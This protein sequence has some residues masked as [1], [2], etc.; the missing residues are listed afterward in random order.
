MAHGA[1]ILAIPVRFIKGGRCHIEDATALP[2]LRRSFHSVISLVYLVSCKGLGGGTFA[3]AAMNYKLSVFVI[4]PQ[5]LLEFIVNQVLSDLF[6]GVVVQ[7]FVLFDSMSWLDVDT[8]VDLIVG[9]KF[10]Q[11]LILDLL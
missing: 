8:L 7:E 3:R 5:K 4:I 2:L 11:F 10:G 6:I 9:V 1:S